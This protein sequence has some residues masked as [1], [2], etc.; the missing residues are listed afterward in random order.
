MNEQLKNIES[1]YTKK[2]VE[3]HDVSSL[4]VSQFF[5]INPAFVFFIIL[6]CIPDKVFQLFKLM[7]R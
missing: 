2:T 3:D 6:H 4:S 5:S 1:E 7:K